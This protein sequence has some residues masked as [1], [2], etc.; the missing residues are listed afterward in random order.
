MT[1]EKCTRYI[2]AQTYI[3]YNNK[4]FYISFDKKFKLFIQT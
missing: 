2:E 1:G 4:L 3:Y